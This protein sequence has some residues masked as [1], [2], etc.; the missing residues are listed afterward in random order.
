MCNFENIFDL[1]KN[2]YIILYN[3]KKNQ[4]FLWVK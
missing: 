3:I 1:L 2:T 4:E